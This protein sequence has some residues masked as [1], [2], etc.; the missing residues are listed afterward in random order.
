MASNEIMLNE[1][2]SNEIRSN[3]IRSNE[4]RSNEIVERI[5]Q[6]NP[7]TQDAPPMTGETT[8]SMSRTTALGIALLAITA[9][10]PALADGTPAERKAPR[11]ERPE[12]TT[13][14]R[15][16]ERGPNDLDEVLVIGAIND[17]ADAAQPEDASVPALPSQAAD[18]HTAD[19]GKAARRGRATTGSRIPD[20]QI[21]ELDDVHVI[22]AVNDP[23]DAGVADDGTLPDL[24]VVVAS[25]PRAR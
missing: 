14:S 8:M 2:T 21:A 16:V 3:E 12:P 1:I 22:G 15:I 5:A 9:S 17:P 7:Q 11:S 20:S 19:A 18:A 10:L 6:A 13:G 23:A 25:A 4:I 24:P